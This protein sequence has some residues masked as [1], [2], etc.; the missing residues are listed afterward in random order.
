[1]RL[2]QSASTAH[3]SCLDESWF[4]DMAEMVRLLLSTT[5]GRLISGTKHQKDQSD[6]LNLIGR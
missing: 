5:E 3:Q 6:V 1:M 4:E 2:P